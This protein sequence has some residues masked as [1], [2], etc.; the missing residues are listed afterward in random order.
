MTYSEIA[1]ASG[2]SGSKLTKILS[3]LERC[4]FVMKFKYYGKKTQDTIIRL[5]DFYT[6]F[7]LRYIEPNK[8]AYD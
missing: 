8:D 2:V 4:D 7:Y 1:D 6:L 5:T 3:N